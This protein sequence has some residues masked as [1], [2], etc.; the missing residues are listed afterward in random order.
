MSLVC[1]IKKNFGAFQL[2]VDI[3]A[4]D[5]VLAL[6]GAS[7]CGKSITLKCI[8]GIVK[9]DS[10]RIILD[11]VTLFDSDKKINLPPQKRHTG[12]LFQDYALFPNMTVCQNIL[13]GVH[14]S[15]RGKSNEIIS[16]ICRIFQLEG[17][18]QRFPSELSG[19]QK[20]R[21]A[22]ARIMA[23]KPK[24]L[25]LDEPFSALDSYLKWRLER[26][27]SS[28]I[29]KFGKTVL[30]VSHN[31]DEV[32]RLCD[33][34]TI[35]E[36]GKAQEAV[37]K[38]DLFKSPET[39]AAALLTG[40]KNISPAL[41]N[42]NEV[43][44]AHWG[45]RFHSQMASAKEIRY[46]GIRAHQILPAYRLDSLENFISFEY[47]LIDEV[48]DTFSYILMISPKQSEGYVIRWE[49]TKAERMNMFNYPQIACIP[50]EKVL[51]L[52]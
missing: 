46:V 22:L 23:A 48:E 49:V 2:N 47:D 5:E 8:A 19:G 9:P 38:W 3:Q 52:S 29:R 24:I 42:G 15:E 44:A 16:D 40:C 7:G 32:Y 20:Q 45:L 1:Q 51:F 30:F 37:P 33:R 17:L 34:I 10:G 12:L 39:R 4:G 28:I 13:T 25:M 18:E 43:T 26:E 27:V 21:C 35:I 41:V 14:K 11:G 31:R 36:N 6:L 50:K